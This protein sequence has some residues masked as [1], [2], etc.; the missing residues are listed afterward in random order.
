MV[1]T[2]Y[3]MSVPNRTSHLLP[4]TP[5]RWALG[6]R[7]PSPDAQ[8]DLFRY[9]RAA[10]SSSRRAA[11]TGKPEKGVSVISPMTPSPFHDSVNPKHFEGEPRDL[12]VDT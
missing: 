7:A 6:P 10:S 4:F 3:C 8:P 2:C 1:G 5:L 12:D 9:L 11:T